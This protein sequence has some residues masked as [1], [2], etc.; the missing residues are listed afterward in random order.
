MLLAFVKVKSNSHIFKYLKNT[1]CRVI[2]VEGLDN[3]ER[4]EMFKLQM[5]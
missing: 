4:K 5:T 3:V 1:K 2:N